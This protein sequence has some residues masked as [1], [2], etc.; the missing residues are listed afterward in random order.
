MKNML[1]T[2]TALV[3]FAGAAAADGHSTDG[4]TFAGSATLGYNDYTLPTAA[5]ATAVQG[6]ND[7]FYWS[8]NVAVAMSKALDNGLT[9]AAAFNFDVADNS[10]ANGADGVAL[11]AGGYVL[12]LTSETAGLY[13]GQTAFAAQTGWKAAGDMEA[14]GFSAADGETVLRGS[15]SFGGVTGYASYVLATADDTVTTDN[16]DQLSLAATGDMG[17]VSFSVAYQEA[18]TFSAAALTANG[19]LNNNEIFGVSAST[20]L[21]GAT[22]TAAYANNVTADTTSTGVKV[23]YPMGPVTVAAYYVMEDGPAAADPK[24][25]YG[26]N[27]AYAE[28]A[29]KIVLDYQ[30]DQGTT[31]TAIDGSYDLG[32]GLTVFAGYYAQDNLS[33][34]AHA[35]EMYVAGSYELGGGA[36]IL[37]AYAD[38]DNNVDDEIGANAYQNGTTVE[39]GFTF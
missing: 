33:N 2:T 22:I 23:A 12:S 1:L 24:D 34:V 37:V 4:V 31:K 11:T 5:G 9:A 3:A 8:A 30:D 38:G 7:G 39:V 19:D 6:D 10:V 20:T 35:N 16:A 26:L 32:N 28:G 29:A 17:N 15:A 25:N 13:F 14:D 21:S 36:S 27:V 18:A